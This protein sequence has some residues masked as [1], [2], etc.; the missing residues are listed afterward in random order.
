MKQDFL[1]NP[2]CADALENKRESHHQYL[3]LPITERDLGKRYKTKYTVTTANLKED[4]MEFPN[5][6]E[7]PVCKYS[8]Y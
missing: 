2:I 7:A 3:S 1:D 8:R 6:V 5:T 4:F